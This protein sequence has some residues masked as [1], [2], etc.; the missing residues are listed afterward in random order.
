MKK[1]LKIIFA[2]NIIISLVINPAFADNFFSDVPEGHKHY[3]AISTLVDYNII[4]GYD[5]GEFFPERNISRSEFTAILCRVLG[6]YKE[7]VENRAD[8]EFSDVIS[9]HW[10]SG[11]INIA[12]KKELINGIGN[13]KFDPEGEIKYEQ[14]MKMIVAALGYTAADAEKEGGYPNGYL[15]IGSSIGLDEN[16]TASIGDSVTRGQI[17]QMIYNGNFNYSLINIPSPTP[18]VGDP[19]IVPPKTLAKTGEYEYSIDVSL[20]YNNNND[21]IHYTLDGS[22]PTVDSALYSDEISIRRT[23]S[24]KAISVDK[25]GNSSKIVTFEYKLPKLD[26]AY[27]RCEEI[28]AEIITPKMTDIQKEMA[29]HDYIALN[30]SF[31]TDFYHRPNEISVDSFTA[32][33]LLFNK[34]GTCGAY[35]ETA[36]FMLSIVGIE[37]I[38]VY[39]DSLGEYG[40]DAH[41]WLIVKINGKYRHLDVTWDDPTTRDK[42]SVRY[43]Y[44][45]VTDGFL[46]NTHRWDTSKYPKCND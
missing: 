22:D 5:D 46:S 29:I 42:R 20:E 39:G 19:N 36:H 41:A 40:W 31:D 25:K 18:K 38:V 37:N 12:Y 6:K 34:K 13:G 24:I 44:F 15:A 11:Y 17:S 7:S 1:S 27:E 33:G 3:E 43:D 21:D 30:S 10:A 14:A 32:Y 26:M 35:T 2:F 9:D 16:L 28:I 8:T 45:N 4:F 23:T